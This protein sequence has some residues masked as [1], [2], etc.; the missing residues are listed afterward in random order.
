M[1]RV[2]YANPINSAVK[3]RRFGPNALAQHMLV[4]QGITFGPEV[5]PE[6]NSKHKTEKDRGLSFLSYQSN[7]SNGFEFVQK[8]ERTSS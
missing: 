5:T 8:S 1:S 4:R 2:S 7:L 3:W 6:E